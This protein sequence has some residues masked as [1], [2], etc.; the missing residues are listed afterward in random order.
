MISSPKSSTSRSRV[1]SPQRT[2]RTL[3]ASASISWS[4]C[5]SAIGSSV[6]SRAAAAFRNGPWPAGPPT[7]L[8]S[9]YV[10]TDR[11]SSSGVCRNCATTPSRMALRSPRFDPR[12]MCASLA[13][14]ASGQRASQGELAD[15]I[16]GLEQSRGIHRERDADV[17]IGGPAEAQA[18]GGHDIRLVQQS[19][20]ELC[21]CV[22][23]GAGNPDVKGRLGSGHVP[24]EFLERPDEG[25]AA[26]LVK[27]ADRRGQ[28]GVLVEGRLR[29]ELDG[30]ED[31]RIGVG[32]DLPQGGD[33]GRPADR[34]A[35]APAGHVEGLGKTMELDRDVLGAGDLQNAG[36]GMLEIHLVVGGILATTKLCVRAKLT[37]RS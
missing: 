5:K 18:G 27:G 33:H 28:R 21:R 20:A 4:R 2:V 16:D 24:A 36:D 1:R 34:E 30:R 23:F 3:P 32:L 12:P 35:D 19:R 11:T 29:G 26:V 8:V 10:L 7:G 15:A 31:A 6:V 17:A 13:I 22:A 14:R 9:W 25:V 37:T